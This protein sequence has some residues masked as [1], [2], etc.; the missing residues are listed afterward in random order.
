[1]NEKRVLTFCIPLSNS[2][3]EINMYK[4]H[5]GKEKWIISRTVDYRDICI[6]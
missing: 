5:Y 2:Y 6:Q 4:D 3:I 1:M